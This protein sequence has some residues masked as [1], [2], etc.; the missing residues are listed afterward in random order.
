MILPK[1]IKKGDAIGIVSTSYPYGTLL[2][3][4]V[5]RAIKNIESIGFKVIVG[6]SVF[7]KTGYTSGSAKER[8]DDVNKMFANKNVRAIICLNGG[9]TTNQILPH[10]DYN[11]IKK[12]PKIIVGSSDLTSILLAINKK[13]GLVTFH[14]PM[15]IPQFGEFPNILQYS[16]DSFLDTLARGNDQRIVPSKEWTDEF[17]DGTKGEDNRPREMRPNN[18]YEFIKEGKAEGVLVGGNL[19]IITGLAGTR[20]FPDFKE[21]IFFWEDASVGI[22]EIDRNLTHLEM[23]DVFNKIKGMVV[24]RILALKEKDG[25]KISD[26]L[27]QKFSQYK[28]PIII[29]ADFGHTD[30][31]LTIPIG[32]NSAID[33]FEKKWVIGKSVS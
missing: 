12:N 32:V 20:Y 4:R 19:R 25:V 2:K 9:S 17:L 6:D 31:V 33:F 21:A 1:K 26:L 24:G 28:F 11:L 13:T 23:L 7:K 10:I 16:L 8:A 29:G 27:K 30:P 5:E 15:I 18:S 22:D 14:G 3:N